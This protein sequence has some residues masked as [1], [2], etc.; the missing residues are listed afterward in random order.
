MEI[1]NLSTSAEPRE[2]ANE[3]EYGAH[4]PVPKTNKKSN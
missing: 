2:D 3:P 1:D 4:N